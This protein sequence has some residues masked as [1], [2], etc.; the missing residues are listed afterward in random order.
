MHLSRKK[1]TL[2]PCYQKDMFESMFLPVFRRFIPGRWMLKNVNVND[3]I[4]PLSIF[5]FIQIM[6][7]LREEKISVY[8]FPSDEVIFQ[9]FNFHATL[10]S[11]YESPICNILSSEAQTIF[12]HDEVNYRK[13]YLIFLSREKLTRPG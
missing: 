9:L 6:A 12:S 11:E 3:K 1:V 7:Q 2:C 4:C 8:E 13:T 10:K 5:V